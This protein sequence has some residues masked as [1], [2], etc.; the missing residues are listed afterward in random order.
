MQRTNVIRLLLMPIA[1]ALSAT[2]ASAQKPASV[3]IV[4][5]QSNA[6]GRAS[7]K[8]CPHYLA[9]GYKH[10][11][12]AFVRTEQNGRFG[13]F[14]LGKT[15]AFCD[16]V[17]HFIDQKATTDFYVVKCTFGG[18]A[19]TPGQTEAGK[20][21]WYADSTWLAQNKP[22]NSS[23]EGMSLALSLTQGF[24]KCAEKT[25]SKLKEGYDV[26]A[27]LWHQGESDRSKPQ[28]YYDNFKQLINFVRKEVYAVTGKEKD[29]R[30]PFIIGTVPRA[31]RQY[32]PM[33]EEA[34]R[35]LGKE[36]PNVHVVDLSDVSLQADVLHFDGKGTEV[37]GKRML[38][39]LVEL[40][41][42]D[43]SADATPNT[44]ACEAR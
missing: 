3:F 21:I 44:K 33:I 37:V 10:L 2:M 18:T 19:I 23:N 27:V 9:K 7:T 39:K 24:E 34:Q 17:N 20:P 8:E 15:F 42:A 26:K 14:S 6:E 30:L 40:G 13:H 38:E 22:H 4:A 32:N 12:Y 35:K 28:Q 16:V 1:F 5:G 11:K 41:L 36:L 43:A 25:L 29:K 31:S